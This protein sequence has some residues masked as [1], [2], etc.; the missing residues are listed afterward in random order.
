MLFH[1]YDFPNREGEG[2]VI[3]YEE[4]EKLLDWCKQ[5]SDIKILSIGQALDAY[6]NFGV[7][8]FLDNR[9]LELNAGFLPSIDID[10]DAAKFAQFVTEKL[11]FKFKRL[12]KPQYPGFDLLKELWFHASLFYLMIISLS[13]F[14]TFFIYSFLAKKISILSKI[15][16]K[17]SF[18]LLLAII[19]FVL[20][21]F[22]LTLYE[23]LGASMGTGFCFG[24]LLSSIS[25]KKFEANS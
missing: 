12:D 18:V 24:L 10:I 23:V 17:V 21:D 6:G 25:L 16:T 14:F 3:T 4:F 5:Q 9:R 11:P 20:I 1:E 8:R 2:G 15:G 19:L 7:D 22:N 13:L